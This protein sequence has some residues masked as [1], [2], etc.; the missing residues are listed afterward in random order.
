MSG[1]EA[2]TEAPQGVVG[3]GAPI[4]YRSLDDLVALGSP[5]ALLVLDH[6]EDP[7]NLG[8][9]ARSALA[10]GID[11]LVIPLRRAAPPG[12][13]AMKAAA[14]ALESLPVAAVNSVADGLERL[15]QLGVWT[16]GLDADAERSLFG[17][18][19]AHRT[20]GGGGRRR[21]QGTW[22]GSS[23]SGATWWHRSRSIPGWRVST[24]RSPL[25]W[26]VSRSA[27]RVQSVADGFARAIRWRRAG[28]A[29]LVEHVSCKDDVAGSIPAPGSKRRTRT[30]MTGALRWP[31]QPCRT[32]ESSLT[33]PS[34]GIQV[35]N[36]MR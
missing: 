2:G 1:P 34:S 24:H 28:L 23:R 12:P 33:A 30:M 26:P 14:G 4:P 5:V 8:A 11:G 9:A 21:R 20:G 15:R 25:H 36:S 19:T 7:H 13:A 22:D 10:A 17:L 6:I 35:L 29:Q 3:V 32:L 18:R 27:G 31:A 16:L